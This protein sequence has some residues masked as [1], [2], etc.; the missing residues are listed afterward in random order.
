MRQMIIKAGICI[1]AFMGVVGLVI[2]ENEEE[3]L[4]RQLEISVVAGK[5]V[6]TAWK[7]DGED[8][9]YLFLPSYAEMENLRL[10]SYS[11]EFIVKEGNYLMEQ[12]ELLGQLPME[13]SISCVSEHT[14]EEFSLYIMKSEN[15]PAVF[16]DT[17]SGTLEQ[18][19]ADKEYEESGELV[20]IDEKGNVQTDVGLSSVK[21]RGNTSFNNY[22]KKPFAVTTQ[23]ESSLLGLGAGREYAFISNASEPTLIRNDI[24][25]A[26]EEAMGIPYAKRGKFV[27][28]YVNQEYQGNYYLCP[29]VE[30]GEDRIDITNTELAMEL[31]YSK[32]SY[33]SALNYET[34]DK[35]GKIL[36][37]N[38][39]DITGGYLV[40]RELGLRYKAD[41]EVMGSGF[42]TGTKEHFVVKSPKYCSVEQIEYLADYFEEAE[43]A[44]LQQDGKNPNTDRYYTDYIDM[45]SFV[46]KYLAEEISKNYDGGVTSSYFYKDSDLIDSRIYAAPG[47]DYDMSLGNYVDWMEEFSGEPKGISKLAHH[48]YATSW[49][50]ALYEK[51]D[52][53]QKVIQYYKEYA[54]PFLDKLLTEELNEYYV[55]LQA[56][57][58]MN[59]V[60]WA[61]ELAKNPYYENREDSFEQLTTFVAQRKEFLDGVW[62][63]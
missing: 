43:Q 1:L 56:S 61:Q 3:L 24:M 21:G 52:F 50:P 41:Y 6:I 19:Q 37:V 40:E 27:D 55:T 49:F 44:I 9:Y 31:F 47:W 12:G 59:H 5:E 46:K 51:E 58:E 4:S 62:L 15:L 25:R 14:G 48:T 33:D 63:E 7:Q 36:E 10:T 20:I 35:K 26:M 18:I 16:L 8:N 30:L 42:I 22:E 60:R 45:D 39:K 34:A 53:Y 28:L 32:D 54:E 13:Y 23:A 29:A 17:N 2:L 38:P 11:A 57:A